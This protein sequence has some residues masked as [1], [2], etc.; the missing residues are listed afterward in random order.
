MRIGQLTQEAS[1]EAGFTLVELIIVIGIIAILATIG[2][3]A[4]KY[5]RAKAFNASVLTLTRNVLTKA[6]TDEPSAGDSGNGGNLGS[7]GP[8]YGDFELDSTIFFDVS[9]DGNDRW[10]FFFAHEAGDTGY[11]FW[12]PGESCAFT[13]DGAGNP[14][15]MILDNPAYRGTVGL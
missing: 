5:N 9:N 10:L 14:S 3:Q 15:D 7:L 8:G 1:R 4:Y 13:T 2:M 12:V 11:Y 6:S